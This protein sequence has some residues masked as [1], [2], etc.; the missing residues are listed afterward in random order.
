MTD[1]A[2]RQFTLDLGPEGLVTEAQ[3]I[4]LLELI[5]QFAFYSPLVSLSIG[6]LLESKATEQGYYT[7]TRFDEDISSYRSIYV[8]A[9]IEEA[10]AHIR[11]EL[12]LIQVVDTTVLWDDYAVFADDDVANDFD[13]IPSQ[14]RVVCRAAHLHAEGKD[15]REWVD[16]KR[17]IIAKDDEARA[18]MIDLMLP[19]IK[20][21]MGP[22]ILMQMAGAAIEEIA[23]QQGRKSNEGQ[24]Q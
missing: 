11:K 14:M 10:T 22:A 1:L 8:G 18:K 4:E 19:Y 7:M 16:A 6:F 3:E 24:V 21:R 13:D 20:E 9:T 15:Y 5:D 23:T 2:D 17:L 12:T